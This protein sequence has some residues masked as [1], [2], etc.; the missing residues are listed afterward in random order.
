VRID[1]T[2]WLA[3]KVEGSWRKRDGSEASLEAT[4]QASAAW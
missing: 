3:L 2:P 4:F 1:A